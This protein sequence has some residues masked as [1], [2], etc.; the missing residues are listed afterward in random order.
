MQEEDKDTTAAAMVSDEAPTEEAAPATCD[1]NWRRCPFYCPA[2]DKTFVKRDTPI[3]H[4]ERRIL[5]VD[6]DARADANVEFTDVVT[7]L[8]NWLIGEEP[9]PW[10]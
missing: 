3:G 4:M 1:H 6:G 7:V 9:P 10:P 5:A 8:G 2:C